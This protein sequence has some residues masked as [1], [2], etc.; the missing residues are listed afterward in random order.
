MEKREAINALHHYF[1]SFLS[2]DS[3][4]KQLLEIFLY[5]QYVR[6]WKVFLKLGFYVACMLSLIY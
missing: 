5:D 4:D 6:M 1:H 2:T 3:L